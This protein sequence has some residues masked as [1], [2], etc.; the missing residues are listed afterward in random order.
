[1]RRFCISIITTVLGKRLCYNQWDVEAVPDRDLT[2]EDVEEENDTKIKS[3]PTTN[4]NI[5]DLINT[6]TRS[7]TIH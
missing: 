3:T 2:Q 7:K 6:L 1:M 5:D 4:Y